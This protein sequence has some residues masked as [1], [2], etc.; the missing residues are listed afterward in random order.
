MG[1]ET[2][3][4]PPPSFPPALR[5]SEDLLPTYEQQLL[6]PAA[7]SQ[8]GAVSE[9]AD[10]DPEAAATLLHHTLYEVAV[11]VFPQAS[12]QPNR[13]Q[14]QH[15][16]Q[17]WLRQ[18][19]WFDREC[20]LARERIRT[21]M[22]AHPVT[23]HLGRQAVRVLA[24]K[25][26][27][28]L[29]Q[30]AALWRQRRSKALIQLHRSD[31]RAFFGKW[32]PKA[33]TNPISAAAWLQHHVHIQQK[34][35]FKPTT[36]QPADQPTATA[37]SLSTHPSPPSNPPLT[38]TPP[39]P[40][41]DPSL[42]R[43]WTPRDVLD[44]YKKLSPSSACLGPLK[45]ALIKAGKEVLAPVLAKLFTAVF[46][47]G[48]MPREW[49][50]GAISAIHKKG[51]V[52]D[53]NNYRGITV[54]HALGKLYALMLNLRLSTWAEANGKRAVGQAGF[55]QGFRTTD[56]CFVLRAL[57]E[58]ARAKGTK[59]YVCAVDLEKAFDSVDRPLLWAA[60]RRSGIKGCM[61]GALQALYADVPVC[62]K[63][64]EGLSST[65]QSTIGVKQGCPLSPLLFGIFLDDFELHMQRVVP[66]AIAQLPLL[67]DRPVPPLLFAD[68][69][70][71]IATSV[72]GLNAQLQSLQEYCDSKKLTVNTAK[73]QV[74]IMRPGGGGGRPAKGEK[75]SY[76]GQPLEVVD[77][78]KY[79]GLTFS[80]LSKAHGF[81]CCAEELAKAGRRALFAMRRRAWELGAAAVLHQS[82]LFDVFVKP[83][84]SYG[85]EIWGVD[86][87]L[88]SDSAPERVHRW[89]CRRLQGLPQGASSAVAV[90]ELGRL[91]LHVHWVQQLARFWNRMLELQGSG[92]LA[93]WAFEDNLNLM[94]E[95]LALKARTGRDVASP[96]WCLRWLRSLDSVAPTDTG[97][98][99]GVTELDEEEVVAR[100]RAAWMRRA[101]TATGGGVPQQQ[102]QQAPYTGG[103]KFAQY[104]ECIRG[105]LPLG[106]PAPHLAL[107]AVHDARHRIC[108]SRFRCSAHHL[109][110]ERDRYLP[111]AIK[112]PRH[113]R[114]CLICCSD[115][116][117]DEHH[118]IFHCPLYSG[119]RF[120][121][122]DLFSTDRLHEFLSQTS[123]DRV[124]KFIYACSELRSQTTL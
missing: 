4:G 85:C 71:L 76:A 59:L 47:S 102:Q 9:L 63:T 18:L 57:V 93:S 97:T 14:Q 44:A 11:T 121:Y 20:T 68:D 37:P 62:V 27:R 38:T 3:L 73:T 52:L 113:L 30:K 104:L 25:Y 101:G 24:S 19:P 79:L 32:K 83:V 88:Q 53:P 35:K 94:Q 55:R 95:Q 123:Q 105:E 49:L 61:L 91:P 107:G 92:R 108:L 41:P 34:R 69:M 31:A 96:C 98:L 87:L 16:R 13:R 7:Q 124:A 45:A 23:T 70:L 22:L 74:M 106:Q 117:E 48:K 21:A 90:T 51:S 66:P 80:Q 40:P 33:T 72:S 10:S 84:L 64:A 100:A 12:N 82:Q 119:L 29:D 43:D 86:V 6:Q 78:V 114:T 39:T 112:P 120:E 77:S 115:S 103:N 116:V 118:F 1:G 89:F 58:R 75:F 99:L 60:L 111:E 109:R 50:L 122:A 54:G 26:Q 2:T 67:C 5:I 36:S 15:G 65:F 17:H 28:L 42:D 8:L 56:N 110:V 81:A 46:R